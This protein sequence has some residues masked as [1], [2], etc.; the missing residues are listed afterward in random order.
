MPAGTSGRDVRRVRITLLN[1]LNEAC[2]GCSG[3]DFIDLTEFKILGG[4]PNALPSG[5]LTVS[6]VNPVPN[7]PVTFDA[8]LV[9]DPDSAIT[10]YVWDFDG[11]GTVDRTTAT[12]TTDFAY[13]VTGS[14]NAKVAVQDFRGGEGTAT[15]PVTV[16]APA[17]RRAGPATLAPLPSLILPRTGRRAA[18]RPSVRCALRCSVRAQLTVSRTTARRLKLTRR[19]LVTLKRTLTTTERRR[20]RLLI[21][22]KVRRAAKRAGFKTIKADADREGDL[23]RRAVEDP[24]EVGADQI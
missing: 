6:K 9:T 18:I 15:T 7:E 23:H 12:P 11:D 22:A 8:T 14:F 2:T 24:P 3:A 20:L 1:P 21:P 19:T 13:G 4:D 16:A 10:G 5:P 17:G